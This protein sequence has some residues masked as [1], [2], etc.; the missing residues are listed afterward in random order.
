MIDFII[1]Q[2]GDYELWIRN[3]MATA[4]TEFRSASIISSPFPYQD[5]NLEFISNPVTCID[6]FSGR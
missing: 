6:D 5:L 2:E 1:L 3:S 4:C